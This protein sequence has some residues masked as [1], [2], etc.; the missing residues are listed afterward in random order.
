M[1]QHLT[2]EQF[3]QL[4]ALN[5]MQQLEQSVQVYINR[6]PNGP[7]PVFRLLK[8]DAMIHTSNIDPGQWIEVD[9]TSDTYYVYR[10]QDGVNYSLIHVSHPFNGT[11]KYIVQN[12]SQNLGDIFD[13]ETGHY[14]CFA[15]IGDLL[16]LI[17]L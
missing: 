1:A 14:K 5:K 13:A 2:F 3:E 17:D 8:S 15:D 11:K 9:F 16:D 12:V 4:H 6:E 7:I 10:T